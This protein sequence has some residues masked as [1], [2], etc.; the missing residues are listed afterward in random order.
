MALVN[1][2]KFILLCLPFIPEADNRKLATFQTCFMSYEDFYYV[3][4]PR[5]IPR[6]KIQ[7]WNKLGLW[8]QFIWYKGN[9]CKEA[10]VI[11]LFCIRLKI[12]LQR[13]LKY[14]VYTSYSEEKQLLF[15]FLSISFRL[16]NIIC[17]P[18]SQLSM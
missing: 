4:L 11:K 3:N 13:N 1:K 8:K 14:S 10:E 17:F 5:K 12:I 9:R 7:R 15:L 6:A 18:L 2:M 16:C